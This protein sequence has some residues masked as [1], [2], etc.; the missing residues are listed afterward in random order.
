MEPQEIETLE[1]SPK[2]SFLPKQVP[3]ADIVSSLESALHKHYPSVSN[4]DEVRSGLINT[5]YNSQKKFKPPITSTPKN[6]HDIKILSNLRK[7]P[8]III[9]K[10]DK[11]NSFVVMNTTDYDNKILLHLNDTIT[12]ETIT[13]DP[14]DQFANNII[15][16][17][18]QL[19]QN[20][21]IAP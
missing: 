10:A 16:E 2:L 15:N 13:H 3:L 19:K 6:L 7:D 17:L 14:T 18:K 1:Q 4:P 8:S 12:Y 20:G 21:K 11:S 9:I 5:L